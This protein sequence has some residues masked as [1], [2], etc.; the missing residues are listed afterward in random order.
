MPKI[1]ETLFVQKNWHYK[2]ILFHDGDKLANPT[3]IFKRLKLL[4]LVVT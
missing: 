3:E 1:L 2:N 4:S